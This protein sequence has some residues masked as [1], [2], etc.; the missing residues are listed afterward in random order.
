MRFIYLLCQS[1]FSNK[2][3]KAGTCTFFRLFETKNKNQTGICLSIKLPDSRTSGKQTDEAESLADNSVCALQ[4]PLIN[5]VKEIP[6]SKYRQT[7]VRPDTEMKCAYQEST[8]A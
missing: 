3:H 4:T 2:F 5:T 7:V 1:R 8:D 6:C